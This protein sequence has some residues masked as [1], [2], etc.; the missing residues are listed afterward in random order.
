MCYKF[1]AS[2]EWDHSTLGGKIGIKMG[3]GV[4]LVSGKC[5]LLTTALK[6]RRI[7]TFIA[8]IYL[9][10][11]A[12]SIFAAELVPFPAR[13]QIRGCFPPFPALTSCFSD[14]LM[15]SFCR[16]WIEKG[17]K[18][19]LCLIHAKSSWF[20]NAEHILRNRIPSVQRFH[21]CSGVIPK[22]V[23]SYS[24]AQRYFTVPLSDEFAKLPSCMCDALVWLRSVEA[25][26]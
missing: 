6:F 3:L 7:S 17:G 26:D 8:V 13:L 16:S 10:D 5:I 9:R 1:D 19:R 2:K 11:L 21:P 23:S 15:E 22:I 18:Y 25:G 4:M 14:L 20:R 24:L 12:P